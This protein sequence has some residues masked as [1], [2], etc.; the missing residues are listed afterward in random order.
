[1]S[2][3]MRIRSSDNQHIE[4]QDVNAPA[5][6]PVIAHFELNEDIGFAS[7]A[8]DGSRCS[9]PMTPEQR[10][11]LNTL[12]A[13]LNLPAGYE[14]DLDDLLINGQP[15]TDEQQKATLLEMRTL[16][17]KVAKRD[18]SW[19]SYPDGARTH[20]GSFASFSA[21]ESGR[22]SNLTF[23]G[24]D[25]L[26]ALSKVQDRP[27]K[28]AR[29][30]R[31][32]ATEY[33]LNTSG[34]LLTDLE[35][36]VPNDLRGQG[37]KTLIEKAKEKFEKLHRAAIYFEAVYPLDLVPL[38]DAPARK[39]ALEAKVESA[40]EMIES[41]DRPKR[42]IKGFEIPFLSVSKDEEEEK[43]LAKE[44]ALTG[45]KTRESY[46]EGCESLG[47]KPKSESAELF[48]THLVDE[49][50]AAAYNQE[51]VNALLDGHKFRLAFGDLHLEE[52]QRMRAGLKGAVARLLE[53]LDEVNNLQ[54][55]GDQD[56]V[57]AFDQAFESVMNP[58]P[59]ATPPV[60]PRANVSLAAP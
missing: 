47:V 1:M 43:N 20:T 18:F 15:V 17:S 9:L 53:V 38:T 45:L 33:L 16:Y 5:D 29:L 27:A 28:L 60:S 11:D 24:Q 40:K 14:L 57:G 21:R 31:H 13:K 46:E 56:L 55:A 41:H 4:P 48:F 54:V 39:A 32:K 44:Y 30:K 25:R 52:Q 36:H 58:P 6:Q 59:A 8:S 22:L 42:K 3:E 7:Q 51:N 37:R 35:G 2:L 50:T 34:R 49:V 10:G 19:R 12:L 26:T 23:N